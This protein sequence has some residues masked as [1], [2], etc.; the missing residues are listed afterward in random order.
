VVFCAAV[1]SDFGEL[2][3]GLSEGVKGVEGLGFVCVFDV[4][5]DPDAFT[6]L[7][8]FAVHVVSYLGERGGEEEA[9]ERRGREGLETRWE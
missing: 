5:V 4:K 2:A 6:S 1:E 8:L 3:R 9:V 7:D